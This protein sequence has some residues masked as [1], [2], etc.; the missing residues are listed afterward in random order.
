MP[1]VSCEVS[2]FDT[3]TPALHS[4]SLATSIWTFETFHLV[5]IVSVLVRVIF[6]SLIP[7]SLEQRRRRPKSHLPARCVHLCVGLRCVVLLH[8][9]LFP[10]SFFASDPAPP[11]TSLTL[12]T[13]RVSAAVIETH[14]C[15]KYIE[16]HIYMK[17]ESIRT[18]LRYAVYRVF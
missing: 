10:P 13:V 2:R 16:V 3:H 6:T 5:T 11:K 15:D 1:V 7:S 4:S 12:S 17:P 8:P 14:F 9:I 18:R